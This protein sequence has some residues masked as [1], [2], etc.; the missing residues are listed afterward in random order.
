MPNYYAHLQ[1]GAQVLA[2]LPNALGQALE[3][4][5]PAFDTGCYGPDPLFFYHPVQDN[6]I[7]QT[8]LKL[9]KEPVR[10][11]A[12]RLMR[13][14]AG[15]FPYARGYAAGFL[16]HFALDA[17]CHGYIEERAA[18]GPATHS[19]MEAEFDRLLMERA[20]VNP[21]R[22]T[23]M[24]RYDLPST[25]LETIASVY[26]GV[27][28]DQFQSGLKAFQR[29]TRCQTLAGGAKLKRAVDAASR[30]TP[31]APDFHGV[32]LD[33]VPTAECAVSNTILDRLFS[34]A[35]P[36]AAAEITGFFQAAF[37][38]GALSS[39]FDRDFSGRTHAMQD[40]ASY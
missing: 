26:P 33:R 39:W 14:V 40:A 18:A 5:R 31:R 12:E 22:Q 36:V 32:V 38:G 34:G 17:A 21:L 19:G 7:R 23:P 15:N 35:V 27:R 1:F 25:L 8:G 9:H 13:A 24:P 28:A 10:P 4:E 6:P 20:G 11:M 37:Q 29:I 30:R 2:T 16:C 3:N